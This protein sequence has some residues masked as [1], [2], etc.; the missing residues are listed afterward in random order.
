MVK[1]SSKGLFIVKEV[2]GI[3]ELD[4]TAIYMM[5]QDDGVL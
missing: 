3:K 4:N 5:M 2:I 1:I